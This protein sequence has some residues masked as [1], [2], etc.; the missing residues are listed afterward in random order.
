MA[1]PSL[2]P[3]RQHFLTARMLCQRQLV[4]ARH[5]RGRTDYKRRE[6]GSLCT[7]PAAS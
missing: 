2:L 7:M 4:L 3:D 1:W 5:L 6:S